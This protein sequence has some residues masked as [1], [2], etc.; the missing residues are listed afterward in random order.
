MTT[1]II[2]IVGRL[3]L[4]AGFFALVITGLYGQS[5]QPGITF[6]TGGID[7]KI[8]SRAFY[9]GLWYPSSS[10]KLKELIPGSDYFFDFDDVKPGDW[11]KTVIS[12]HVKKGDA[13]LCLDFK[14][15]ESEENGENEPEYEEDIDGPNSGELDEGMEFFAWHDDGDNKYEKGEKAIF[16][17]I[18]Q[19]ADQV[20]DD[21][22]Y[23]IGDTQNGK[24]CKA[25]ESRY[26]GIHW[27]AGNLSVNT[28]TAQ[29][30]CD[31]SVLGNEA[32][33]DI[34]SVDV[35]I[36]ALPSKENPRFI[37]KDKKPHYGGG[38]GGGHND[39][40]D[41]RYKKKNYKK[42]V[43]WFSHSYSGWW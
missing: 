34:L 24:S 36:R 33:T 8:D 10:W 14:N 40:D 21:E 41:D 12:M 37:C 27:C 29:I 2:K 4:L 3:V 43:S 9:N 16:N 15:L 5:T 26:V 38:G 17:P 18:V 31:G 7:L 32:Q 30:S 39:D 6:A 35:S 28:Y 25:N 1:T 19:S 11:G 22:T 23:P 42:F 13:W 20:L